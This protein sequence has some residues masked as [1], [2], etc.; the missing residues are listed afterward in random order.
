MVR[1]SVKKF[2]LGEIT[3]GKQKFGY[4]AVWMPIMNRKSQESK[5]FLLSQIWEFSMR[6]Y[7]KGVFCLS[8]NTVRYW[9][10]FDFSTVIG[11]TT[12]YSTRR[13]LC[14]ALLWLLPRRW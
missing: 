8:A 10:I 6:Y 4:W 2:S 9:D 14:R 13:Y 12:L 1:K 5:E 3:D 7:S 11:K